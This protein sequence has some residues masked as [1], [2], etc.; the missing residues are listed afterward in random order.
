LDLRA[1]E[2]VERRRWL[3]RRRGRL[4]RGCGR[5][6][7]CWRRCRRRCGWRR[8]W[9]RRPRRSGGS[10]APR[11]PRFR[12]FH[13]DLRNRERRRDR[14]LCLRRLG[15][16]RRRLRRGRFRR[17]G[18]GRRSLRRR[19][20]RW[21]TFRRRCRRLRRRDAGEAEQHERRAAQQKRTPPM[22]RHH[23]PH[24]LDGNDPSAPTIY[25]SG[26]T[27]PHGES[28]RRSLARERSETTIDVRRWEVRARG[29]A[30]RGV[31]SDQ[32]RRQARAATGR[33]RWVAATTASRPAPM[34]R[35]DG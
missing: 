18:W 24:I 22:D 19:R 8:R 34:R 23:T 17:G 15:S 26:E 16:G 3:R 13:R 28:A 32:S 5:G 25:A 33:K 30:R 20:R 2:G 14:G 6:R 4:S 21:R 29:T 35:R 7:R 9:C 12:R 1:V 10:G 27:T 11:R 31:P